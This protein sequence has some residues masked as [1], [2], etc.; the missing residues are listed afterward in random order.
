MGPRG[1]MRAAAL[2]TV[3]TFGCATVREPLPPPP[4]AP[5]VARVGVA[6]PE[7]LLWA[8]GASKV[9][10]AEAARALAESRAALAAALEGRG[11]APA[12]GPADAVLEVRER[13][14]ARTGGRKANQAL[15]A[16]G[17][18]V[19]FVLLVAA[20]VVAVASGSKGSGGKS[21]PKVPSV[22][23]STAP[24]PPR[25][26]GG[27][28]AAPAP[29]RVGGG[30]ATPPVHGTAPAP[31]RGPVMPGPP[32]PAP[33]VGVVVGFEVP[34]P[35]PEAVPL[36]EAAPPYTPP[37]FP[38]FEPTQRGFFDGDEALLDLQLVDSRTGAVIWSASVRGLIDPRDREEVSRLL[39]D[40]LRDQPWARPRRAPPSPPAAAPPK[41][42]ARFANGK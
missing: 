41:A 21:A 40:V 6:E 38:P 36:P 14:V 3:L 29:P 27:G 16:A 5:K 11:A 34:I 17:I 24:A 33:D 12:E 7:V 22:G 28:S 26:G 9:D 39:D 4:P 20:F 42:V 31:P 2:V 25:V 1:G 32:P 15:A 23:H 19:G 37:S 10:P 8:E 30:G 13:A 18:V 35:L